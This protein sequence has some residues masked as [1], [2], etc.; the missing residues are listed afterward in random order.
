MTDAEDAVSRVGFDIR[1]SLTGAP[2]ADAVGTSAEP[3]ARLGVDE[4]GV[5]RNEGSV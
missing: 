2:G 5:P 3:A 1:L 4:A